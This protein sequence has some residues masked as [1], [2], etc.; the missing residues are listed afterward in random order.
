MHV[1]SRKAIRDYC[2][3]HPIATESLDYWFRIVKK[4]D[5]TNFAELR[6]TFSNADMVGKC[7]VFN[8]GG[9]NYRLI[10]KIYFKDQVCLIRNILS[11][12]EYDKNNW[13]P[14]CEA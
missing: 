10:S 7:I 8:I 3:V 4:A 12:A 2:K 14:N 5:W 6:K 9:N 11:H 13:K 1:I